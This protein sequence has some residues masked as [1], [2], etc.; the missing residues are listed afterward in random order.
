MDENYYEAAIRH[1]VDGDILHQKGCYDNAVCLY[2]NSA[3]CSLK[4]LIEVYYGEKSRDILQHRYGH[5]VDTLK[6]ELYGFIANSTNALITPSLDPVLGLKL[7][8]FDMPEILYKEHPVQRYYKNEYF[9]QNDAEICKR[10][11]HFLIKE[12]IRQHID[13]YI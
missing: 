9:S 7:Q 11:A 10:A 12:L 5:H 4:S 8:D 2:C 6:E 3:E 1:F 13:G